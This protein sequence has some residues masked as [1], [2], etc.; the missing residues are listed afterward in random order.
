M[1]GLSSVC[2]PVLT[3]SWGMSARDIMYTR[4]GSTPM[5]TTSWMGGFEPTGG[6]EYGHVTRGM[7]DS[8]QRVGQEMRPEYKRRPNHVS[9]QLERPLCSEERATHA[10]CKPCG[11]GWGLLKKGA[12]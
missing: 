4:L 7:Q 2:S 3:C 8:T 10:N 1:L 12:A 11:Q 9:F 6:D 5:S